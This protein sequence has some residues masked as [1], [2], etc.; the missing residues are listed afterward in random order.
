MT[1][2]PFWI[3]LIAIILNVILFVFFRSYLGIVLISLAF[4]LFIIYSYHYIC[5]F[6]L[7]NKL[8]KTLSSKNLYVKIKWFT[9]KLVFKFIDTDE[10]FLVKS[11]YSSTSINKEF[12]YFIDLAQKH[13]DIYK[14]SLYDALNN[15][16]DT[17]Y[18]NEISYILDW[19]L[20]VG[21]SDSLNIVSPIDTND[22]EER[23]DTLLT[24]NHDSYN[25]EDPDDELINDIVAFEKLYLKEYIKGFYLLKDIIKNECSDTTVTLYSKNS[26]LL[27]TIDINSLNN[28][29]FLNTTS[30]SKV[31]CYVAAIRFVLDKYI[32]IDE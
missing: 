5:K 18:L 31:F 27:E 4:I 19:Y 10:I 7:V 16:S 8:N 26:Y 24:E 6:I 25:L 32:H 11:Y 28:F 17:D 1:S 14:F 12:D 29:N 21:G 3:P 15:I 9:E 30:N 20:F 23:I 22:Y 2:P 13:N